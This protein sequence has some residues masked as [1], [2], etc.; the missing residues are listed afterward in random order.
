VTE[1]ATNIQKHAGGGH[2]TMRAIDN[3]IGTGIEV[4]AIDTGRGIASVS[5][6]LRDGHS[7]SGTS[8]TGLGSLTRNTSSFDI[9]SRPGGG[10][11]L[12]FEVWPAAGHAQNTEI[13][14]GAVSAA[15]RG[16]DACGDGWCVRSHRGRHVSLVVDGLGH[17]PEAATAAAAALEALS[18][19]IEREPEDHIKM[20]HGAL[21]PTRGA[22]AAVAAFNSRKGIG[23][24]AGIGNISAVVVS[25]GASRSLVS[26]NGTLGHVVRKTKEFAFPFPAGSLLIMHSDG[27]ATSW[28]LDRYP[29]LLARHPAL[30]AAVLWRDFQR[31]TDDA[32]VLVVRNRGKGAT[33]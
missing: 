7:T 15:K 14:H 3:G 18:S 26:L 28:A 9:Y 24:F 1:A 25:G 11:V 23:T 10:T 8:G 12:R 20:M 33:P 30:I 2:V 32:T 21:R 29:G 19:N 16:Q 31:G 4:I 17:G 6:S 13:E 5:D 22:A 27:I